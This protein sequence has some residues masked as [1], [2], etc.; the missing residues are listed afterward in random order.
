MRFKLV[1][2]L[3]PKVLSE[4]EGQ[5]RPKDYFVIGDLDKVIETEQFLEKLLGLRVHIMEAPK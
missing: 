3:G 2:K 5:K 4:I 1:I